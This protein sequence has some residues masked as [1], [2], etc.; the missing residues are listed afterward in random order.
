MA[1]TIKAQIDGEFVNITAECAKLN[2][3]RA[4]RQPSDWL[5][6]QKTKQK[7]LKIAN[8]RQCSPRD[9]AVVVQGGIK[10]G[11]W[12]D[13]DLM[14]LFLEWINAPENNKPGRIYVLRCSKT[15]CLKIGASS[16]PLTRLRGIQATYPFDLE[17]VFESIPEDATAAEKAI[18]GA[19]S[20]WRLNGEWF[21][22]SVDRKQLLS[23]LTK[24]AGSILLN[25][26]RMVK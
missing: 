16:S 24:N 10:Q 23:V 15:G 2:S 21:S 20:R 12:I 5:R 7:I 26:M 25:N 14:P 3:G 1:E 19:L 6:S 11:T 22:D 9:L 18:H 13:K 4:R 8:K 17:Q